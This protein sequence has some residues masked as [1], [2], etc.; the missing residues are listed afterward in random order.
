MKHI[1]KKGLYFGAIWMLIILSACGKENEADHDVKNEEE[2]KEQVNIN[3]I[4]I[5][6][7]SDP[8]EEDLI[9]E[10]PFDEIENQNKGADAKEVVNTQKIVSTDTTFTGLP[11]LQEINYYLSDP[12]NSKGL[13]TQAIS[14]SFGVARDGQ[15]HHITVDNQAL[16]DS[17]KHNALAWDNKTEEKVLYLTWDCG[18]EYETQEYEHNVIVEEKYSFDDFDSVQEFIEYMSSDI[19]DMLDAATDESEK[20]IVSKA[21]GLS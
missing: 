5:L 19:Y 9:I 10:V 4:P 11:A 2:Q 13:S 20:Q 16:F 1:L 8:E 14:H 3:D 15:P 6:Y 21:L 18:Y 12:N 7:P 17:W